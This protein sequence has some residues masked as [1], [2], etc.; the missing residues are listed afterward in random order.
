MKRIKENL[1]EQGILF[2]NHYVGDRLEENNEVYLFKDLI[3][4]LD[5][6]AI[7]NS[8]SP[9]GGSMFAPIDQLAVITFALFK[10]IASSMMMADLV[11]NHLQFIKRTSSAA[12][13]FQLSA[14]SS[15]FPLKK[16]TADG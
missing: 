7:T 15:D 14:F 9:E 11:R 16:L 10:G 1:S 12:Y 8:Y 3:H 4:K 5:T 13:S 2:S 6:S